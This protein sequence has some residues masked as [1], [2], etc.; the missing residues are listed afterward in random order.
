[1][2]VG[3]L[4]NTKYVLSKEQIAEAMELADRGVYLENI[5]MVFGVGR[6]TLTKYMRAAEKYGYS[7]WSQNPDDT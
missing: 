2:V 5:A 3:D 1:M 6:L 4:L 7:F